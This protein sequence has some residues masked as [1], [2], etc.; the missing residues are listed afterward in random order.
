VHLRLGKDEAKLAA[1][2]VAVE[3]LK[4]VDL[5]LRPA[6]SRTHVEVRGPWSSKYIVIVIPKKR[7]IVGM[8]PNPRTWTGGQDHDRGSRR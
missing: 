5:D 3:H 7:L 2:Q 4:R 6:S 8:Q 1:R